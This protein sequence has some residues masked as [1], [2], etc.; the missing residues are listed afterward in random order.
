MPRDKALEDANRCLQYRPDRPK[1]HACRAAALHGYARALA[2]F[3]W[4]LGFWTWAGDGKI[5]KRFVATGFVQNS[6]AP[7]DT[8]TGL[9]RLGWG[10]NDP[11]KFVAGGLLKTPRFHRCTVGHSLKTSRLNRR[12]SS[13]GL[14]ASFPFL[15]R[16]ADRRETQSGRSQVSC[17]MRGAPHESPA[18]ARPWVPG[19]GPR[20]LPGGV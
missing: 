12:Q 13:P 2:S 18:V 15:N 8:W 19:E 14:P 3:S 6:V 10:W 17:G 20:G 7:L 16:P 4:G 11:K 5:R 1:G 9:A